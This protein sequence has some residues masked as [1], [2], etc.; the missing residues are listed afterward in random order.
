MDKFSLCH[1][2]E[3]YTT[4]SVIAVSADTGEELLDLPVSYC[5]KR[6]ILFC[7]ISDE[8]VDL[9]PLQTDCDSY[10]LTSKP[11]C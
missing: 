3:F 10:K 6:D 7:K 1:S 11:S 5:E 9:T 4:V 2:C 8:G